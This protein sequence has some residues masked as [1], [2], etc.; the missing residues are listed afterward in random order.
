MG[1][2][3]TN[4]NDVYLTRFG[5]TGERA[6]RR[7]GARGGSRPLGPARRSCRAS[8]SARARW[9]ALAPSSPAT[10]HPWTIVMGV[11]ARVREPSP[12]SGGGR[13]S[14][15]SSQIERGEEPSDAPP[16]QLDLLARR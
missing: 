16:A 11:P 7:A 2:V 4:D 5:L 9:W 10:S 8:R 13:S 1:V 6:A 14:S 12:R 3:T 15:E